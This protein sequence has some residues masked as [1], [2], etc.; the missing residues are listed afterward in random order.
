MRILL[1][2][3]IHIQDRAQADSLSS[4]LTDWKRRCESAFK[5]P[6]NMF[7]VERGE[8]QP[9]TLSLPVIS[10]HIPDSKPY[11]CKDWSY[12][13]AA[14]HVG[15]HY[16]MQQ[17]FD[18]CIIFATD[19]ILGVPL[20]DIAEEFMTR[21]EIAAGPL[22]HGSP[23]THLILLKKQGV[24]DM[25]YSIPFTPLG[26]NRIYFEH[27][28]S[29]AFHGRWWNPW[30]EIKTVRQEYNTPELYQGTD[31]EIIKSWPILAKASPELI[32]AYKQARP[33]PLTA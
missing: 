10:A 2:S 15:L 4:D 32:R 17:P 16:A 27:A 8:Y 31:E 14:G 28:L 25:L 12:G 6:P 24:I 7:L 33:I 19:A 18:L 20:Q 30:P 5:I 9:T 22:W 29:I 1:F 11:H 23:D 3:S 13:V 21:S 26:A